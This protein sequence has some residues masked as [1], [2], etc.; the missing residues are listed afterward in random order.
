[1][2]PL[3]TW[4][5]FFVSLFF[6]FVYEVFLRKVPEII[7]WGSEIGNL[8]YGVSLS[9]IAGVV[10]YFLAAHLPRIR[11]RRKAVAH[12]AAHAYRIV[13]LSEG[14]VMRLTKHSK[15]VPSRTYP[16]GDDLHGMLYRVQLMKGLQSNPHNYEEGWWEYLW[17]VK[18]D[19]V[20]HVDMLMPFLP[21]LDSDV[22][23]AFASVRSCDL[24]GLLHYWE[25]LPTVDQSLQGI[26]GMVDQYLQAVR[27]LHVYLEGD[28][29]SA[30]DHSFK[31]NL[32]GL[33]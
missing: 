18:R 5:L 11:D 10:F 31:R 25:H 28:L 16:A 32:A 26:A 21:H 6:A 27:R 14:V 7:P 29:G 13:A 12:A 4:V 33:T 19:T 23:E 30:L 9:Y 17:A 1:M 20:Y 2:T 15:R 8:F 24:F 3:F 22:I